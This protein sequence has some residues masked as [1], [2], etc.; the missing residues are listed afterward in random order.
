MARL[1]P[2]PKCG[3]NKKRTCKVKTF[4]DIE[5]KVRCSV[6]GFETDPFERK[7]DAHNCWNYC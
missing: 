5:Y 7:E 3:E 6:C 1:K 2:C 4:F